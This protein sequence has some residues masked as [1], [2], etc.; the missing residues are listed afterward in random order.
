M[1]NFDKIFLEYMGNNIPSVNPEDLAKKLAPALK[2]LPANVSGALAG[3]SGAVQ[4]ATESDPAQSGV[5]DKLKDPNSKYSTEELTVLQKLFTTI[6]VNSNQQKPEPQKPTDQQ[7]NMN[8][9]SP[10]AKNSTTYG[11]KLQGL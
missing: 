1:S 7:S 10:E 4:N 8:Q 5:I 9:Q 6:G 3:V 11:G 2:S